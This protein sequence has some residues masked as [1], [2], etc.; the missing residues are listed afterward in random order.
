M[1]GDDRS[2][3]VRHCE[4]KLHLMFDA[5]RF[6]HSTNVAALYAAAASDPYSALLALSPSIIYAPSLANSCFQERT[7]ASATTPSGNGDVVGS[8]KD[9]GSLGAWATAP[10]DAA[11]PILRVSGGLTYLEFD[12]V[13]DCLDFVTGAGALFQNVGAGQLA[14]VHKF[15]SSP[16]ATECVAF[17]S[18]TGTGARAGLFGGLTSGRFSAAGRRLD[19]DSFASVTSS[20][21]ISTSVP[22]TQIAEFD[23]TNSDLRQYINNSLDGST[24]SFQTDGS[25]SNSASAGCRIGA[26]T[27]G[28]QFADVDFY[29]MTAKAAMM[30]RATVHAWLASVAGM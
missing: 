20:G 9:F 15:R 7:G 16:T 6:R 28:S 14:A 1:E 24:T 30:D 29:G 4:R 2:L 27:S 11:R 21:S 18:N 17:W 13:D 23:W 3:G 5:R 10:S 25:T 26:S 22:A 12:G 8:M 19:A